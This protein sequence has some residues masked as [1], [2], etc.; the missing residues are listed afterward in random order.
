LTKNWRVRA[1]FRFT[2]LGQFS[3]QTS[4]TRSSTDPL[5]LPNIGSSSSTVNLD[6]AFHTVCVRLAYAF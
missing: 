6:A 2:D 3:K 5:N 4:L 1:E